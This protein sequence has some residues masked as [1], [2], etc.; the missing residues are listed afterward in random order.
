MASRVNLPWFLFGGT[1]AILTF[2]FL[3]LKFRSH[4]CPSP[5]ASINPLRRAGRV[6]LRALKKT[7]KQKHDAGQRA[8]TQFSQSKVCSLCLG[9]ITDEDVLGLTCGH[10]FHTRCLES[11]I[12][13]HQVECPLCSVLIAGPRT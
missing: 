11:Q 8:S 12:E 4:L 1:I 7:N 3:I 10:I 5:Q 13:A 2:V 6:N 9:T